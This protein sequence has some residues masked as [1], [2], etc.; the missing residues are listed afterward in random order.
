MGW[1]L[2][3]LLFCWPVSCW[4]PHSHNTNYADKRARIAGSI[5]E[6]ETIQIQFR[7]CLE[8]P[9][10]GSSVKAN[11]ASNRNRE[12]WGTKRGMPPPPRTFA[13]SKRQQGNG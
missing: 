8:N 11:F 3:L 9:L 6:L 13:P 10:Y 1:F 4:T 2:K 12:A 5:L 7:F